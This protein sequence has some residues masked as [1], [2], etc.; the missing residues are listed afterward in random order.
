MCS[1]FDLN[2]HHKKATDYVYLLIL[3]TFLLQSYYQLKHLLGFRFL[4]MIMKSIVFWNIISYRLIEDNCSDE[5]TAL[6]FR[7]EE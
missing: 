4:V 2:L 6:I 3:L 1:D 5:N 7:V